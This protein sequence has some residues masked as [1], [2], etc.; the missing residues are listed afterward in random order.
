MTLAV[1]I[2]PGCGPSNK[3]CHQLQSKKTKVRLYLY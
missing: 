3:I 2:M 1:D